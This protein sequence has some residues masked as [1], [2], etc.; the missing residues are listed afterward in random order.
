ME[1]AVCAVVCDPAV[2]LYSLKAVPASASVYQDRL[3]GET[4]VHKSIQEPVCPTHITDVDSVCGPRR[5][6]FAADEGVPESVNKYVVC[7]G[8]GLAIPVH[9]DLRLLSFH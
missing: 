7:P 4:A 5:A 9:Y 3:V 8:V 1:V 2:E 6:H